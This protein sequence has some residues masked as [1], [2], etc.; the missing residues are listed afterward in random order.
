MGLP[1]STDWRGNGYDLIPVIINWL[2]I[3]VYYKPM[4]T[5]ITAPTLAQ[6]ILNIV[7][8]YHSLPNPIVSNRGSVFTS[9]FCSSLC[10]FLSIKRRLS[11]A[12]YSQ[13]KG[14]TEQYNSIMRAYLRV[15]VN[16]KKDN[17]ARLLLMAE[18]AY[19][20]AKHDSTGYTPFELNCGYYARVSY[21]E[22]IAATPSLKQLISW[23]RNLEISWLHI[24]KT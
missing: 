22:D 5:A 7:V 12:F 8:W 11:I 20:N 24:E 10:Y 1:Q 6:V 19:N 21:K 17:W 2:T 23:L 16:Y 15:F 4:Q 18:F 9:K 14:Q 3:I 13:T